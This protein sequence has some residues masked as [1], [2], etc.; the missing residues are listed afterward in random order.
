M[1]NLLI[2][3]FLIFQTNLVFA[4][5]AGELVLDSA[6]SYGI[7]D[8][9]LLLMIN[10]SKADLSAKDK[11]GMTALHWSAKKG[12]AS[13]AKVLCDNGA[14]PNA[15]DNLGNT[16]LMYAVLDLNISIVKL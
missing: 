12:R 10:N 5:Y 7:T 3:V 13:T 6:K 16:P 9:R 15:I 2:A 11:N 4:N 1:K 14:D 8:E